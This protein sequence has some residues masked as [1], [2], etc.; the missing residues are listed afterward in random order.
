MIINSANELKVYKAAYDLCMEI[1]EDG[2]GKRKQR[3]D[4][5][6]AFSRKQQAALLM[7][8]SSGPPRGTMSR[9]EILHDLSS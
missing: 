7:I 4:G 1:N 2:E 5:R 9:G 3:R 6:P 8:L